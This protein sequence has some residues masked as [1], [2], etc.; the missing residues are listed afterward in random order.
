MRESVCAHVL[1]RASANSRGVRV[2]SCVRACVRDMGQKV[3]PSSRLRCCVSKRVFLLLSPNV[4]FSR[5]LFSYSRRFP[6]ACG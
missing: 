3:K 6:C 4:C 1:A 5:S 2:L